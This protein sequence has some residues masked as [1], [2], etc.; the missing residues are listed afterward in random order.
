MASWW[1]FGFNEDGQLNDDSTTRVSF[2][3]S[4]VQTLD[5]VAQVACSHHAM[6]IKTDGNYWAL[7]LMNMDNFVYCT[8]DGHALS[9]ILEK[10]ENEKFCI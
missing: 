5:H 4:P 8:C 7:D 3:Y 6:V 1:G 10:A 2:E 9:T